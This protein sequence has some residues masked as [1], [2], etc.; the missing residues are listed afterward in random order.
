MSISV[1]SE[2]PTTILLRVL[3]VFTVVRTTL[4]A[5][6]TAIAQIIMATIVITTLE[7]GLIMLVEVAV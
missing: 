1:I 3:A 5:A 7:M 2:T 4:A 6:A